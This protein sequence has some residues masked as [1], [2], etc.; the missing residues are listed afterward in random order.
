[1]MPPPFTF[2]IG[3]IRAAVVL[4]GA[5]RQG[6]DGLARR[7]PAVGEAALRTAYDAAGLALDEAASSFNV[8]TLRIGADVVLIDTGEGGRPKGGGLRAGLA[9]LGIA[10]Q[11]VTRVILTHTHGDHVLGL[12]TPEGE[13]A[14]PNARCTIS[15]PELAW[16]QTRLDSGPPEQR[17][18]LA[19]LQARGLEAVA[20]DAPLGP[21]LCALPLPGHTPGQ[22]GVLIEA[23][24][25]RLLHAADA[26]HSP[27]QFAY[28]EWSPTYDADGAAAAHTRQALLAR[29]ADERLPLLFYHLG[30]PG[31][32]RVE[33]AGAAFAWRANA[34]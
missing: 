12:L 17:A 5:F 33:R 28:P 2:A 7:F 13:L 34:G 22:I 30:F 18:L 32:G 24:G 4:D 3:G 25:Q 1:M 15:A 27:V 14:F 31:L 20:M 21:G 10:P 11:A 8:L 23:D 9:A 16:W 19:L 29:A 6:A 26:L